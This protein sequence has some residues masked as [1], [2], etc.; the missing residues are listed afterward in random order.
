MT[1][2]TPLVEAYGLL[3]NHFIVLRTLDM[4]STLTTNLCV[5]YDVVH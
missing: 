3:K 5:Q 2:G 4:R 1:S